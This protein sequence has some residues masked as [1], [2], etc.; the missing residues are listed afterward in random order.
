MDYL[1][2]ICTSRQSHTCREDSGMIPFLQVSCDN[3]LLQIDKYVYGISYR[4]RFNTNIGLPDENDNAWL[5]TNQY[6]SGEGRLMA[7]QEQL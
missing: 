1:N 3:V 6:N 4:D 7:E 2:R 5:P